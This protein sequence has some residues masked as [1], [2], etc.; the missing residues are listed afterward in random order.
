LR[1]FR[2][3]NFYR[4]ENK[5][6]AVADLTGSKITQSRIRAIAQWQEGGTL[7]S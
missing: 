4:V 2:V 7:S 6:I 3:A 1:D 5:V